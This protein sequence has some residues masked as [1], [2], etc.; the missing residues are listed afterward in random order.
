MKPML[1]WTMLSREEMRQAERLS[2]SDEQET[3]DE[4]G[5][6]LLHQGFAD[7]FFPGTSVLH[8]RLRYALFVPWLYQRATFSRVRGTPL[9]TMVSRLLIELAIRLKS[10]GKEKYGVIGGDTLRR[11]TSQPPDHVYWPA[12][13]VWGLLSSG[14]DSRSEALR[15]L[16]LAA[17]NSILDDD[18]GSLSDDSIEVFSGLPEHPDGWDNAECPLRF[19][20]PKCER[21]FL[22]RKLSQLTRPSDGK[23]ALL[24]RLVEGSDFFP[25]YT[26]AL[27]KVLNARADSP[28]KQALNVARDAAALAAIGRTVYGALVEHLLTADRKPTA[29]KFRQQLKSYFI[30]YGNAAGRCDLKA[31]EGILPGLPEYVMTVLQETQA[32][33]N[34]GKPGAFL[35]L[36][37]SYKTAETIR[38]TVGRARLTDTVRGAERRAEWSPDRHNTKPLHYRWPVVHRMLADLNGIS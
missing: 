6:L 8:T 19:Y 1:G 14:V 10:L 11:L 25:I 20:M 15:R 26:P 21:D 32:Y 28:D 22:R 31:I 17:R 2:G 7:R 9:D 23:V 3:R 37:K 30:T 4:V 13:R 33:V 35:R 34:D 16:K 18:G 29:G 24:S 27:P 36:H 12:L 5:F 38:K